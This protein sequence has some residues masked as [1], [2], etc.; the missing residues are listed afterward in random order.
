M[1]KIKISK[2]AC[3]EFEGN[4]WNAFNNHLAMSNTDELSGI[5]RKAH[6]VYWYASEVTNG[7]HDQYFGNQSHFN[8]QEVQLAL[9]DLGASEHAKILQEA[10]Q[11]NQEQERLFEKLIQLCGGGDQY[12]ADYFSGN[13]AYSK[14]ASLVK[15]ERESLIM[16]LTDLDMKLNTIKPD[17][18]DLLVALQKRHEKEMIEWVD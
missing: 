2:K 17:L 15:V 1:T 13:K 16:K 10:V 7:G 11:I 12:F 6:L 14:E 18:F 4:Y 9:K 5:I 3:A 8:H